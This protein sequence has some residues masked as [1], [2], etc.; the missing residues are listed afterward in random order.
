MPK[1][2]TKV[3][4]Q[5]ARSSMML[6]GKYVFRFDGFCMA[7]DT[8]Y[9]LAGVGKFNLDQSNQLAGILKS[10]ITQIAGPG[11]A[12]SHSTYSIAG[13]WN[14]NNDEMDTA[15]ITFQSPKQTMTGTFDLVAADGPNH[16][17]LIST[18]AKIAGQNGDADEVVSG[19]AYRV[20]S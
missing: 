20:A 1:H 9:F 3:R 12:L 8:P 15:T 6:A 17:W 18:G 19:E 4:N 2:K 14:V 13:T 5:S 16:F 7:E 11:A 10:S